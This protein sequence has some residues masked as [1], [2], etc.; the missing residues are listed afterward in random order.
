[1]EQQIF[2]YSFMSTVRTADEW[3]FGDIS[4]YFALLD[5]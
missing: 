3:V 1:M 5:F 4:T 2:D